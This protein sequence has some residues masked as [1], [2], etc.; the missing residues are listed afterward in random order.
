MSGRVHVV[1]AGVAGLAAAV[2]L[3]EAGRAVTLY[4]AAPQAGGRARSYFDQALGCRI[5]NG[6]HLLIAGNR[7]ALGF[8][9]A[10]GARGTL[11]GPGAPAYPFLD[12]ATG[13]RWT[14]R[15]NR[16]R[17][18]WWMASPA[19]RVPGTN[20][21]DYLKALVLRRARP[22]DR[23][24][25]LLPPGT[26]IYRRLWQPLAV[27]ALNTPLHEASAVL[28]ARVLAESI[29]AGGAA[30]TPLVPRE[31]LS[32]TLVDPALT[33]LRQRGATI[34]FGVRLRAIEFA[35][36]RAMALDFDDGREMLATSDEIVLAVTAPVASRLVPDLVAPDQYCAILNAHY[37]VAAPDG[38]PF[39][40]GI[41]GGTAEWV[42]RK[43]GVLS[44]T[45]SAADRL[46]DTPEDE[47]A[48]T[49]WRD[50]AAAYALPVAPVPPVRIVRERRATFA[51]TPEQVARR[52][53]A[54]TRWRNLTLA[55]DWTNTGLPAT[56]EGAIRSGFAAAQILG[57]GRRD[58]V[59][60]SLSGKG[61][62]FKVAPPSQP[63]EPRLCP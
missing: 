28:L 45:V 3:A 55:G 6:N 50:V 35:A 31:G 36:E 60:K 29:G 56:L 38:S 21:G 44:V 62:G 15:F 58:A 18:P 54:R 40:V 9:D 53:G 48:V 12:R 1:G 2:R 13:E 10:V 39:F 17:I 61:F 33:Q 11:T 34:R 5:D 22:D 32:E 7:S 47:L 26:P 59:E 25:D 46:L 51:A 23:V 4:E 20:L 49:L 42:F 52:P 16:G 8:I 30:C 19:R 24:V 63:F 43:A 41:I 14:L 57:A 37:R 27:A